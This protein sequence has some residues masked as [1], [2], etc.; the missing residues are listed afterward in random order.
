M[1]CLRPRLGHGSWSLAESVV[2]P[3]GLL[4]VAPAVAHFRN[5]EAYGTLLLLTAVIGAAP[6]L[7][8]GTQAVLI[9]RLASRTDADASNVDDGS[10]GASL[11]L[12]GAATMLL[13]AIALAWLAWTGSRPS[14]R[15]PGGLHEPALVLAGVAGAVGIAIDQVSVG[16]LK[17]LGDFRRSAKLELLSR[18][19]QIGSAVGAAAWIDRD[20]APAVAV[21][22]A[23]LAGSLLRLRAA[24]AQLPWHL[25]DRALVRAAG[26]LRT[27]WW[28]LFGSL[29]GYLYMSLD[30]VIVGSLLGP[31]ALAV[32]GIGVQIA[33]FCLMLPAAYFQP[34][35]PTAARCLA[36]GRT[37]AIGGLVRAASLKA[38]GGVAVLALG[39]ALTAPLFV[40]RGLAHAPSTEELHMIWLCLAA[41]SLMGLSVPAYHALMGLGRFAAVSMVSLAAGLMMVGLLAW[42]GP[43]GNVVDC[44]AARVAAGGFTLACYLLALRL[45]LRR[46][47]A[48]LL[49]P[50]AVGPREVT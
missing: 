17:G 50:A 6:V 39:A 46:D 5:L 35:M 23:T 8:A 4:L 44:A 22:W 45:A 26:L 24:S 15:L 33:Q 31:R 28:M 3:L 49:A 38:F 36:E 20:I 30:R 19:L 7:M 25:P 40:S 10:V 1:A 42:I 2:W 13:G 16:V 47:P 32:Y 48:A 9:Q 41:A 43:G 12:A 14:G 29:G 34:M 27:G 21:G 18:S 37:H 11:V